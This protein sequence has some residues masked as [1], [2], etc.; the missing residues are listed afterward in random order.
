M[1]TRKP[2][3]SQSLPAVYR[4]RDALLALPGIIG[5]LGFYVV[6][7]LGTLFF[8]FIDSNYNF[9]YVGFVHYIQ[10]MQNAYYQLA[11]KNTLLFCAVF[12]PAGVLIA[13]FFSL[14]LKNAQHFRLVQLAFLLPVFLPSASVVV[15]WKL[16]FLYSNNAS[17][18]LL[19]IL[20]LSR[21]V[22]EWFCLFTMMMWKSIGIL[23]L[24]IT[25]ALMNF[26][27]D[28]EWASEID[29]AN[30]LQ[31]VF[32]IIIPYLRPTL[33]AAAV[34]QLTL[35][36]RIFKEAYLLYGAYPH[37][38]LYQVQHYMN[39][40]FYKLNYQNLSSGAVIFSSI[41]LIILLPLLYYAV[42]RES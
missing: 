13:F 16:L 30:I 42:K 21:D 24:I 12:V 8:S 20:V 33:V 15:I 26:D 37:P 28:I 31:R 39:N 34:Y 29:G 18:L 4:R 22:V 36:L 19:P 38:I 40:H 11:L 9:E 6:P 35:G 23:M 1:K 3:L 27:K 17:Q 41:I 5:F 2:R 14:I 25:S 32:Y 7:F 10:T